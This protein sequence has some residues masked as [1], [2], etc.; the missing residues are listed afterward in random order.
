MLTGEHLLSTSEKNPDILGSTKT[1]SLQ[2]FKCNPFDH[3]FLNI[4]EVLI[5][6]LLINVQL[7]MKTNTD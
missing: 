5:A 1:Y 2:M 3:D 7:G 6:T 4:M